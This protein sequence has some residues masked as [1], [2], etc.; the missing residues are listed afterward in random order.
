MGFKDSWSVMSGTRKGAIIGGGIL[1][2]AVIATAIIVPTVI[3]TNPHRSL[4]NS[5]VEVWVPWQEDATNYKTLEEITDYYNDNNDGYWDVDLNTIGTSAYKESGY[6][7]L[8]DLVKKDLQAGQKGVR[9]LPDLILS[10]QD[11]LSILATF[12]DDNYTLS[13]DKTGFD[14]T[15]LNDK[16]KQTNVAG[17]NTS[18]ETYAIPLLTTQSLG[19][20]LPLLN[21]MSDQAGFTIDSEDLQIEVSTQDATAID[22]VWDYEKVEDLSGEVINDETFKSLE[23]LE[24]FGK[25]IAKNFTTKE[26]KGTYGVIG[27]TNPQT[28]LMTM[29][30]SNYGDDIITSTNEGNYYNFLHDGDAAYTAAGEVYSTFEDGVENGAYWLPNGANTY[31]SNLIAAHKLL[32]TVGST[33]G[34]TYNTNGSTYEASEDEEKGKLNTDEIL[35]LSD[36]VNYDDG[37]TVIYKQQGPSIM[38][39][40]HKTNDQDSR[41]KQIGNFLNFFASDEKIFGDDKDLSA[42]QYF[43]YKAGYVAGTTSA[44]SDPSVYPEGSVGAELILE[45]LNDDGTGEWMA[46]PADANTASFWSTAQSKI[47]ANGESYIDDKGF[48]DWTTYS[49][50]MLDAVNTNNWEAKLTSSSKVEIVINNKNN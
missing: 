22:K 48:A 40:D 28:E 5:K 21:W 47:N 7:E 32:V 13:L 18:E 23:S 3:Y 27:F 31:S 9:K 41:T 19:I 35:Y 20:D 30:Q 11:I 8:P 1:A 45:Q 46:E 34:T 38:A 50:E 4:G 15:L 36:T 10:G 25:S 33:S 37:G 42:T 29:A 43:G 39:V 24:K 14:T 6:T 44:T 12:R 2:V 49:K 16:V 17:V 26:A